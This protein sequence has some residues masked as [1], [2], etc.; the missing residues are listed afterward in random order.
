MKKRRRT[1]FVI[2]FFT[3]RKMIFGVFLLFTDS[4]QLRKPEPPL[5]HGVFL[6]DISCSFGL[7][8]M[9]IRKLAIKIEDV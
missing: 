8:F 7:L 3:K 6:Y 2:F 5:V 1:F 4:V 9:D